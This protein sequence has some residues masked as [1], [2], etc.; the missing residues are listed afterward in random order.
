MYVCSSAEHMCSHRNKFRVS[1]LLFLL[2][3][4]KQDTACLISRHLMWAGVTLEILESSCQND[5]D[6]GDEQIVVWTDC[7]KGTC[8]GEC[9]IF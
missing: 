2:L 7:L 8:C 5:S 1:P 9:C 6:T 3:L 4:F